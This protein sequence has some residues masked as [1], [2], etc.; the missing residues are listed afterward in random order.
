MYDS[1]NPKSNPESAPLFRALHKT[2]DRDLWIDVEQMI[3][4]GSAVEYDANEQLSRELQ[5]LPLARPVTVGQLLP[6]EQWNGLHGRWELS[7][8]TVTNELRALTK[9][10][11]TEFM[12]VQISAN[13][14][15]Q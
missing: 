7:T 8:E 3:D 14:C 1:D 2:E 12:Q 10:Q 6:R 5:G 13:C 15:Y 11:L 4:T 9:A